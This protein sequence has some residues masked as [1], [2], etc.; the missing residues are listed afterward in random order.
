[1]FNRLLRSGKIHKLAGSLAQE[2]GKR[3]PS[4]IANSPEP[5][6]SPRRRYEILEKIFLLARDFSREDQL[7]VLRRIR[8]GS[9]LKWRLRELGY[10]EKFIDIAIE[11]FVTSIT[12]DKN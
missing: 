4:A 2:I 10:D 5:P 11:H 1:M 9:A 3:Y 12:R 6:V 7:G 8:L